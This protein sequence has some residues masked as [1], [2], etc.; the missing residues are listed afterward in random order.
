MS[1]IVDTHSKK[2]KQRG[3]DNKKSMFNKRNGITFAKS[4]EYYGKVVKILGNSQFKVKLVDSTEVNG[5]LIGHMKRA[6]K[7][8]WVSID[9][10]V[11]LQIGNPNLKGKKYYEIIHKYSR[12][13]VMELERFGFLTFKEKNKD[14]KNEDVSFKFTI[15][16]DDDK[17]PIDIMGI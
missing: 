2:H 13:D 10:I 17:A 12:E 14:S 3:L 11:L 1:N 9:D 15:D 5:D 4:N 8:N 7:S 6:K 16:D